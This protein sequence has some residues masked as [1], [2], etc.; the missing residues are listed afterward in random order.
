MKHS[1][2]L[3]FESKQKK[4]KQ[5][6]YFLNNFIDF[7]LYFSHLLNWGG[8]IIS[9]NKKFNKKQIVNTCTIDYLLFSLWFASVLSKECTNLLASFINEEDKAISK[10]IKSRLI[11]KIVNLIEKKDWN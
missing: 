8:E 6:Q 11:F 5:K 3:V 7:N 1:L 2:S 9:E 4:T 10:L